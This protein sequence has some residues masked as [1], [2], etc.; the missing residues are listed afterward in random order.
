MDNSALDLEDEMLERVLACLR[1]HPRI[2]SNLRKGTIAV[3]L[4]QPIGATHPV[5]DIQV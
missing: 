1:G 4:I 5:H 2:G 3:I